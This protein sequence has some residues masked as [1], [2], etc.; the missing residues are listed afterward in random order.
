MRR[1][2][3]ARR[4]YRKLICKLILIAIIIFILFNLLRSIFQININESFAHELLWMGTNRNVG[5]N[6]IDQQFNRDVGSADALLSLSIPAINLTPSTNLMDYAPRIPVE[7][8]PNIEPIV[9]IYNTHQ[10]EDFYP[11]N[12]A[13]HNIT[14][15]VMMVS[16]MLQTS[17]SDHGISSIVEEDSLVDNFHLQPSF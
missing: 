5:S 6:F 7:V 11:G 1:R 10:T 17:L 4:K 12:L 14:P 8:T 3:V 2:F 13:Y 16:Y 9:Y 15:N